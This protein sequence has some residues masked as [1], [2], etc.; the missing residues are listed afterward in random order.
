[1]DGHAS[2]S[3]LNVCACVPPGGAQP[4]SV[5]DKMREARRI[6]VLRY[7]GPVDILRFSGP[8]DIFISTGPE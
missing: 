7:S 5:T 2:L 1:M 6:I 4:T 8:V 3:L